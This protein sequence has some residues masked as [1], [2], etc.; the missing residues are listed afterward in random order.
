V[1][2]RKRA[3]L[4]LLLTP[5]LAA[6]AVAQQT[7]PSLVA[8]YDSLADSILAVRAA[9]EDLVRALLDGHRHAA[10]ALMK[11]GDWE[12]VAAQIALFANEGDNAVAGVRKRLVEGGHHHNSAGEEQ[13][14][15]EEGYVVVTRQAKKQILDLSATIRRAEDDATRQKAWA[16]FTTA[17]EQLLAKP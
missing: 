2:A 5:F 10:E 14:I 16:A 4:A 8:A 15:Y 11:Q 17:A 6:V 3:S 9:E 12:G 1:S 13:G 7:P